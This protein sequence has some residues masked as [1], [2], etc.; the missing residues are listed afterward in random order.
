[1]LAKTLI[2]AK[3]L[4]SCW[5]EEPLRTF[6]IL[7]HHSHAQLQN[8]AI[9]RQDWSS[10]LSFLSLRNMRWNTLATILCFFC[11][12]LGLFVCALSIDHFTHSEGHE[13]IL[14][15]KSHIETCITLLFYNNHLCKILPII[16][17][18]NNHNRWLL[19][20][21]DKYFPVLGF[22]WTI[23]NFYFPVLGFPWTISNFF[24]LENKNFDSWLQSEQFYCLLRMLN[25]DC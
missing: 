15:D 2:S 23:S 16:L 3:V 7:N 8:C 6:F 21:V 25:V 1:M 20:N 10:V 22:P 24:S 13:L 17:Y 18:Y 9:F 4:K 19:A 12:R 5:Y 11:V 14:V